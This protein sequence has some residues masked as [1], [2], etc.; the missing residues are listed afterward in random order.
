MSTAHDLLIVSLKA[1]NTEAAMVMRAGIVAGGVLSTSLALTASSE[2]AP[3]FVLP[4]L[5]Y[6]ILFVQQLC[7]IYFKRHIRF[8]PG[9][10]EHI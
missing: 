7:V 4:D 1:T 9:V 5:V 10:C 8:L 6:V 3:W 2:Y